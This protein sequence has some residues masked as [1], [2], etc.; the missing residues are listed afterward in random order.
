MYP[1]ALTNM[2]S[3][4]SHPSLRGDDDYCI[5]IDSQQR[6]HSTISNGDNVDAVSGFNS[7]TWLSSDENEHRHKC[8]SLLPL[9]V[10]NNSLPYGLSNS[11]QRHP[12][13][14]DNLK[15]CHYMARSIYG[16]HECGQMFAYCG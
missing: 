6:Y 1:N 5:V 11:A 16:I 3:D 14:I 12:S 2:C 13:T 7:V 9:R 4:Y 8:W 10:L 15:D